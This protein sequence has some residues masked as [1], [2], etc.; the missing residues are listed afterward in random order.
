MAR[1]D[2]HVHSWHSIQS[3]NLRFLKSRDCYSD[4]VAVYRAAKARGMDYVCLTDHD[5]IDGCIEL[6]SRGFDDVIVAEEVSCVLPD[7]GIEVHFGVYGATEALHRELQ[8][9]RRNAFDVAR[10]LREQDVFFSLNH[11]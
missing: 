7:S 10:C 5:S 4:P 2:L 11:L 8:P 6:R 3:G 1:A 9:L